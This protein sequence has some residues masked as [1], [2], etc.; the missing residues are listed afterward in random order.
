MRI[1]ILFM[2]ALAGA[3]LVPAPARAQVWETVVTAR[4][5]SG[6]IGVGTEAVRNGA[7]QPRERVIRSIVPGSAAEQAGLAVGD[8]IVRLN[9]LAATD[10]VMAAPFEVGDTITLRIRRDGRERDITVVAGPRIQSP[11]S[12]ATFQ[13][14]PDSV[15]QQ[16]TYA[17]RD[18]QG[19]LDTL[20][21]RGMMTM[22]PDSFFVRG[23][24]SA[25]V[26][27]FRDP[28]RAALLADSVLGRMIRFSDD[29]ARVFADSSRFQ[30]FTM[31]P[32]VEA[33]RFHFD[34]EA[35]RVF[36]DSVRFLRPAEA[37]A[38]GLTIGM[39]SVA[40]AELTELND[41]LAEY[42]GVMSGVLVLNAHEGTPAAEAGIRAGDVI[43]RANGTVV[44]S[45]AD[46]RRAIG[47]L[48]PGR[49]AQLQV[50]RHGRP[51]DIT[52]GR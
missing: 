51:V 33:A 20:A 19:R 10:Q 44:N 23:G 18:M 9:G 16:V 8:I 39:R 22:S 45:V 40:G 26:F 12:I 30:V 47:T 28:E 6:M 7:Q 4:Q 48:A 29:M 3:T 49:S 34:P 13:L 35:A 37:L 41:G 38:S 46:L 21:I 15:R 1:R 25:Q 52:L 50:L 42:F 14:L 2:A 31:P 24:D 36:G 27:Y 32:G 17:L 43:V 11:G 5:G